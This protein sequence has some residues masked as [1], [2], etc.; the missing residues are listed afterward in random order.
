MSSTSCWCI[1]REMSRSFFQLTLASIQRAFAVFQL[2][3]S[4]MY[5]SSQT[6]SSNPIAVRSFT[7]PKGFKNSSFA[8]ISNQGILCIFSSIKNK[9]VFQI[10]VFISFIIIFFKLNFICQG[11]NHHLQLCKVFF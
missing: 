7:E 1:L 8:Y 4:I 9:G 3:D 5:F 11:L 6:S 2:D 10:T